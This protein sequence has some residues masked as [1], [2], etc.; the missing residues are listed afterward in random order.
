M[1]WI[2]DELTRLNVSKDHRSTTDGWHHDY[3]KRILT[4]EK[5]IGR[6]VWGKRR[7]KRNPLTGKVKQVDTP[8]NTW[9]CVTTESLRIIPQ[10]LWD[11]AQHRLREIKRIHPGPNGAAK[12]RRSYVDLYPK[13]AL[14][15][16]LYC[17]SCGARF[18]SAGSYGKYLACGGTRMHRCDVRTH[19][20]RNRMVALLL[21]CLRQQLLITSDNIDAVLETTRQYVLDQRCHQPQRLDA[22]LVRAAEA[23]KKIANL[24]RI[25][26]RGDELPSAVSQR[27]REL[28]TDLEGLQGEIRT[29]KLASQ[30]PQEL[31]TR[32]SLL[33]D[34]ASMES[35]LDEDPRELAHVLH[36]FTNGRIVMTEVIP[37]GKRRGH[38]RAAFETNG[39]LV[40]SAAAKTPANTNGLG[41]RIVADAVGFQNDSIVIDVVPQ[42]RA[43]EIA[44][45]VL[46]MRENGVLWKDIQKRFGCGYATS[47]LAYKIGAARQ[48]N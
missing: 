34:L 29:A 21:D 38:F 6:W 33:A 1:N 2:A 24:I 12:S 7:S 19:T 42:S 25:A 41:N 22:L 46:K 23:E 39:Q 16:L 32:D 48:S 4:C 30:Q 28:E 17:A 10:E 14:S 11:A 27:I 5:Y 15:G 43:E 36:A 45:A 9:T 20:P 3:I 8:A 44:D 18:V 35:W 31:P 47:R 37:N 40:L 13:N 26:E